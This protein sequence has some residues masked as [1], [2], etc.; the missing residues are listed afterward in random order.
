[1]RHFYPLLFIV[2]A[3]TARGQVVNI[4][5]LRSFAD[6]NGFHGIENLNVDYRKN[7]RELLTLT[8]NLS[9]KYQKQRHILLFLNTVDVQ[10]ANRVVLEQ[11]SFFHLRYNFKQ[12]EYLSYEVFA[13]YQ[14]NVPLR[15]DARILIGFGP[16]FIL[17]KDRKYLANV[18]VLGMLEHDDEA[19]NEVIH[20]DVRMSSYLTLGYKGGKSFTWM[21]YLYYQPRLDYFKDYRINL[22]SQLQMVIF[23]GL[24]FT[25]TINFKYDSFPV[26]DPDIPKL[27]LH[28]INGL[29][30]KF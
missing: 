23:K 3:V 1:M 18:G 13:Q 25:S 7:T 9:L 24:A 26:I 15:I 6:S 2:I 8:N 16:R 14:R 12:N 30:Y 27:T 17:V 29:S 19:G 21:N 20:R 5:S 10:L 4:E 22:E 28:W 11:T